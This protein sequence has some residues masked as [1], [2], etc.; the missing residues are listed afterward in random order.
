[1]LDKFKKYLIEK[2]YKLTTPSGNPSTVYDYVNRVRQVCNRENI[3][4]ETLAQNINLY[5]K[6]YDI[7]GQEA[8]FGKQSHYSVINALKRFEE[9]TE[10]LEQF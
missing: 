3:S 7:N 10:T 9:F 4:E 2:G 5:V 6:K 1:M 8:E